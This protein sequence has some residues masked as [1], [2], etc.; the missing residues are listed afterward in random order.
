MA[1]AYRHPD[2]PADDCVYCGETADTQDHLL[3]RGYTGEAERKIVPVVPACRECNSTLNDIYMPDVIERR[4]Y[5]HNKY[6]SKYRKFLTKVIWGPSDLEQFGP[7][8]RTAID[9]GMNQH[10]RILSR[11]A[12]PED[13]TYDYK[14]WSACWDEEISEAI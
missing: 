12:W 2:Y 3:P 1:V 11:L 10:Y 7:Q 6:R 8:I 14:A 4:N 9:R 13:P 5:L